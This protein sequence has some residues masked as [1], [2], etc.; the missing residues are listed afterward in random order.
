MPDR[1]LFRRTTR[2]GA[3]GLLGGT[4]LAIAGLACGTNP[5]PPTAPGGAIE[6][7][8]PTPTPAVIATAA[9][10]APKRGG[11][12]RWA[13]AG[14]WPHLDPHQ[15][16]SSFVF[17]YGVGVCYSRLLKYKLPGVKLPA[18]I[19]AGDLAESWDQPDDVTYIFKLRPSVKWHNIPP[20]NGRALV[21]D[22]ITFSY[23][24]QRA[25]GFVNGSILAAITRLE[26]V[27]KGTIKIT[28]DRPSADFLVNVA[29]PQSVVIAHEIID[30]KG[31]LKEGPLIGTGP[32]VM[33]KVD[34]T[35][36][37]VGR[38][39]PDYFLPGF[40]YVDS[41]EYNVVPNPDAYKAGFRTG[42]LDLIHSSTTTLE[43]VDAFKRSI[44][45]LTVERIK[46]L[47]S[48]LGFGL[49]MDRPPFTDVRV[50]QAV[51]K[52]MDPKAISTTVFSTGWM[53]V[54]LALP[55]I[56]WAL[57]DDE[58]ARLNQRDVDAARRLLKEAGLDN[59]L[60]FTLTA[61][62]SNSAYI[63]AAELLAAQLNDAK[64]RMT[65]KPVDNNTLNQ[66]VIGRGEFEAYLGSATGSASADASLFGQY[67]STGARNAV[68]VND[69]KL[70]QMI[71]RQ[72]TLGRNPD[73]RKSLLLDIQRYI[74]QQAYPMNVH[75]FENIGVMQPYVRDYYSGTLA[76]DED[77]WIYVWLDK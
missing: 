12:I 76:Q 11:T 7:A 65:I 27:D 1:P 43:D 41:Y 32:F 13:A 15:T 21:A 18:S 70:D 30:Q 10:R 4:G 6:P 69:P 54:G 56:E 35:G 77:R 75:T 16:S 72:T 39:N 8:A 34:R 53:S 33:E 42:N 62:N 47:D 45:D 20:V 23:E 57:P 60:E 9:P 29:A 2:R 66:V 5:P 55:S 63:S 25:P 17:G 3:L 28:V 22:D 36:Q 14:A 67:H 46:R 26:A 68:K 50:R 31:D 51:Y 73:A 48:G 64:I 37:S 52:A 44:P 40:P 24:R 59:G 74:I 49:K 19:P 58:I 61:E 38:R 71:E